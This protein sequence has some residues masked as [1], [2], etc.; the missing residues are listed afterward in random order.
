MASGLH[1]SENRKAISNLSVFD[2]GDRMP[3]QL[4]YY[5]YG[6][7]TSMNTTPGHLTQAGSAMRN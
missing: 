2:L 1:S 3:A 4:D 7:I 6:K 5:P